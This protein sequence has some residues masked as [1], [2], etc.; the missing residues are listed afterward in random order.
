MLEQRL[1]TLS[2]KQFVR[3]L[4]K[5]AYLHGQRSGTSGER[6]SHYAEQALKISR[7]KNFHLEEGDA[8]R[9]LA[10]Y[11][12]ARKGQYE[13]AMQHLENARTV[14]EKIPDK[15]GLSLVFNDIA[16]IFQSRNQNKQA[17]PYLLKSLELKEQ[18]G[19]KKTIST[20]M[21][22][23][24]LVYWHLG[25]QEK[26]LKYY[27]KAISYIKELG[28][29]GRLAIARLNTGLVYYNMGDYSIALAYYLK[30][31]PQFEAMGH[32]KGIATCAG[33]IGMVYL[34]LKNYDLSLE[35]H[36]K[37]LE[38]AK[39]VD[40][41][42]GIAYA[43]NG[44]GLVFKEWGKFDKALVHY[45]ISLDVK[46]K[47]GDKKG[48]ANALINIGEVYKET[49]QY[50]QAITYHL[51]ALKIQEE[52][53]DKKG[54]AT[55]C[56]N[57]GKQYMLMKKWKNAEFY[58]DRCLR[59]SQK[60]GAKDLLKNCYASRSELYSQAGNYKKALHAFEKYAL[61]VDE[62]FNEKM[63]RQVAE[64][65]TRYDTLKKEKEILALK[66][67]NRI[68]D[69]LINRQKMVRN[70]SIFVS[71]LLVIIFIQFFKRYRYL[72]TFWKKRNYVSHFQLLEK[73]GSGGM[74]E[75][76]RAGD[77]QQKNRTCAVKVLKE[78]YY[79]DKQYRKR[80]KNEAAMMDQLEHPN[81]VNVLERGEY[82]GKLYIAMEL[83]EGRTLSAYME[84]DKTIDWPVMLEIMH[85]TAAALEAIHRRGIVHRD[86]KPENIML[87]VDE[88]GMT[89]VKVL[90]FGL[91][92]TKNLTRLTKTGLVVGTIYYSAPEQ[93]FGKEVG[94]AGDIYSLGVIFFQLITGE[95]PF[96]GDSVFEIGHRILKE[97]P[98]ALDN[99]CPNSPGELNRLVDKMLQK[100]PRQR[101]TA[102]DILISLS[103]SSLT[104]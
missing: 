84:S 85:Q 96:N 64:M 23:I 26:A 60:I 3:C 34:K 81:I 87:T 31:L 11:Y 45:N 8:L 65:Q 57:I 1:N 21:V 42:R 32:A 4:N 62:I 51:D 16:F 98:P 15:A 61:L 33:N 94:P 12:Y 78:E 99:L 67:N 20:S 73:I 102:A 10:L 74:G 43:H 46:K 49:S 48:T 66:K 101:P 39:K 52:I 91:A 27:L 55:G 40:Y 90:D 86:L 19:N 103:N 75:I 97:P 50:E 69:L 71:L 72:F 44:I 76:Y 100:D 95:R 38:I 63:S 13:K 22:N 2:G 30:A 92:L 9:N 93:L 47:M 7:Q 68:N 37:S 25:E 18:L 82:E 89:V 58:I 14:F 59:I 41:K 54:E 5:L 104:G 17:L 77:V 53:G 29:N 88:E 83:L 24:G 36:R 79:T 56:I 80:F 70:V 28:D 6:V 35:Y